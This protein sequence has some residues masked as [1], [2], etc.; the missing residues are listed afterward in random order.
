MVDKKYIGLRF[1]GQETIIERD[2]TSI[3]SP[4]AVAKVKLKLSYE[5]KQLDD[6]KSQ[7]EESIELSYKGGKGIKE[8][9][10]LGNALLATAE[11]MKN[12]QI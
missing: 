8:L 3:R 5:E 6:Y 4:T 2:I 1:V 12:L 9:T 7:L 10:E 11:V